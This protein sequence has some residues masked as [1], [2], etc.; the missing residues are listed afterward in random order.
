VSVP[1]LA[2]T[3]HVPSGDPVSRV[4]RRHGEHARRR[5]AV[6]RPAGG[7]RNA[8]RRYSEWTYLDARHPVVSF[9]CQFASDQRSQLLPA[10]F[11]PI[12]S[13]EGGP[14]RA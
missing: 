9:L 5:F 7:F 11:G 6:R 1:E 10:R 4:V 2:A 3:A 14:S 8:I 13:V 12:P